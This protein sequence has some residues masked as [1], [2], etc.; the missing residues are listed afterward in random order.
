MP[1]SKADNIVGACNLA[2]RSGC[3][4]HLF[5]RLRFNVGSPADRVGDGAQKLFGFSRHMRCR[6]VGLTV[7]QSEPSAARAW[8]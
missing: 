7:E 3:Q 4:W 8:P 2:D 5:G 6:L 1:P